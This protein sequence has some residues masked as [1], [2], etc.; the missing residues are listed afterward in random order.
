MDV[1]MEDLR[2]F[3]DCPIHSL[4]DFWEGNFPD[5]ILVQSQSKDLTTMAVQ[6]PSG[7][8]KSGSLV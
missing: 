7:Q 8:L 6:T 2:S 4:K 5:S 1:A 3:Q